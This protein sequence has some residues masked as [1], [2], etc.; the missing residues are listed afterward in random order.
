MG[1]ELHDARFPGETGAYRQARDELLRAEIDLRRQVERV[2]AQ[3]REL[4]PGGEIP[5]DYPFEEWDGATGSPRP[6]R[7]SELFG[8]K[9]TLFLYSFMFKP[10]REGLPLEVPCE[11][12][13]SIIDAIDG[14]APHID[15]HIGLAVVAKAPIERFCAHG[16]A[17]GWRN[18]R[19]VSSA[20]TTYNRD[21]KAED[22]AGSQFAMT[23]VFVR[24]DGVIRHFWS[25]ELWYVDTEPGQNPRHVDF[26]W[27]LW[28]VLDRTPGGR[29][30]NWMPQL[31]Y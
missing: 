1:G 8:D 31:Q 18:V 10:G 28:G 12:C 30:T 17:R 3:R 6:V 9:D 21:Y 26:M 13:T 25:S 24:Q 16:K 5:E 20:D 4:P 7:L 14:A 15:E 29:G 23:T 11:V 2:A 27:P 22:E 19:L